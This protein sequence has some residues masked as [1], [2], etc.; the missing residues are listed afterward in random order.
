MQNAHSDAMKKAH[1]HM[2]NCGQMERHTDTSTYHI[3]ITYIQIF[4]YTTRIYM[5]AYPYKHTWV[6][7]PARNKLSLSVHI[8]YG[9]FH[10]LKFLM[11]NF[12]C[13]RINPYVQLAD[14]ITRKLL[15]LPFPV[16]LFPLPLPL[17]LGVRF[18]FKFHFFYALNSL[19]FIFHPPFQYIILHTHEHAHTSGGSFPRK[20][21]I[22]NKSSSMCVVQKFTQAYI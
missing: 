5:L 21:R 18:P 17:S 16:R 7:L 9:V 13:L 12:I 8:N 3:H 2:L 6:K 15:L 19:D 4:R 14:E 11:N 1:A 22:M 20:S 10:F